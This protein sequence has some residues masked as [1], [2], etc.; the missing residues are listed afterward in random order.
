M[1]PGSRRTRHW[2]RHQAAIWHAH[3]VHVASRAD[4]ALLTLAL[5]GASACAVVALYVLGV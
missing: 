2:W 4:A 3:V 1:R 5:I